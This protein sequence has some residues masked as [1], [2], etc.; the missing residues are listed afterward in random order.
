M[1]MN[2]IASKMYYIGNQNSEHAEDV[3][4]AWKR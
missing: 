1:N 2:I 3:K 4:S